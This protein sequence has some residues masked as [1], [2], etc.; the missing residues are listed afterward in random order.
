[1]I[2]IRRTTADG[3]DFHA[4]ETELQWVVAQPNPQPRWRPRFAGADGPPLMFLSGQLTRQDVR[5]NAV[6]KCMIG[7]LG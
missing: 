6:E 3:P 4:Q 1:V 5:P 7:V 2:D